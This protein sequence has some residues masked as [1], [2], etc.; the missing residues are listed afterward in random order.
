MQRRAPRVL[1]IEVLADRQPICVGDRDE[2]Q[3]LLGTDMPYWA[4]ESPNGSRS[5]RNV[6]LEA[7]HTFFVR[8]IV[9]TV[10][11]DSSR[12]K[13]RRAAV[14]GDGAVMENHGKLGV[15]S[16]PDLPR[17]ARAVRRGFARKR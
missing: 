13:V 3:R 8:E 6:E 4:G 14:G 7:H 11:D 15:A 1:T 12:R 9:T 17:A 5:M 10:H 16:H 2:A